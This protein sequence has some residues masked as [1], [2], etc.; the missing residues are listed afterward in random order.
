MRRFIVRIRYLR[1][2]DLIS[3]L[4]RV[5][6][7]KMGVKKLEV[8]R[9]TKAAIKIQTEWRRYIQRKRYLAHI[10]LPSRFKA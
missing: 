8:A 2:L 10:L 1:M 9:Q 4:Q 3:R 5:A 7:Q 6:R